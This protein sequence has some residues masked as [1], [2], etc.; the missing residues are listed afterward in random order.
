MS[1]SN[2]Y[3]ALQDI[4]IKQDVGVS[5]TWRAPRASV[6]PATKRAVAVAPSH[7][8]QNTLCN[9]G[10]FELPLAARMSIMRDPESDD[11]TK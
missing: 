1:I 9:L 8:A 11:V 4:G 7:N 10:G 6:P 2:E 3:R 5:I